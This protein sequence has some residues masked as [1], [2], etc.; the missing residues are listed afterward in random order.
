MSDSQG[1]GSLGTP[2]DDA[3]SEASGFSAD[4][5]IAL[6]ADQ[7]STTPSTTVPA[8]SER[9]AEQ[10]LASLPKDTPPELRKV[11]ES[12]TAMS[13]S[14]FGPPI[15]SPEIAKIR[16]DSRVKISE[17]GVRIAEMHLQNERHERELSHSRF[18]QTQKREVPVKYLWH[19]TGA[20]VVV[21]L[22]TLGAYLLIAGET[23]TAKWLIGT[24]L[25]FAGGYGLG[26]SG[27]G[28]TTSQKP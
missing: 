10:I 4:S 17:H 26:R 9:S 11:F 20:V 27:L 7:S 3:K 2:E 23:E 8:N 13:I 22:V 14:S 12:L 19:L 6:N 24:G 5:P 21:G 18:E 25:G 1:L 16:E 28:Q 15:Q